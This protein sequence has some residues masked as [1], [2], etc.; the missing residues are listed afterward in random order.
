[1]GHAEA[2]HREDVGGEAGRDQVVRYGPRPAFRQFL[3]VLHL[4]P[5]VG[6]AGDRDGGIG[7]GEE[8]AGDAGQQLSAL[9]TQL[10][11]VEVELQIAFVETHDKPEGGAPG[12]GDLPQCFGQPIHLRFGDPPNLVSLFA[13]PPRFFLGR[14]QEL[15]RVGG[16]TVGHDRP[17]V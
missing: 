15:H 12:F 4:T 9:W 1:V 13:S 10:G 7:G 2:F 11:L 14:D 5:G 8:D 3:V 16:S 17:L 6:M